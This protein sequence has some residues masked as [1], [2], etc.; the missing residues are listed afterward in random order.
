M[1]KPMLAES[2]SQ[3][4]LTRPL[5][6]VSLEELSKLFLDAAKPN[7]QWYVGTEVELFAFHEDSYKSVEHSELSVVLNEL[8]DELNLEREFESNNALVGLKG[9]GWLFH[10]NPVDNWS[11]QVAHIER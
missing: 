7:T 1:S 2:S 9:H 8:A 10:W 4:F 6:D 11:L 5:K 3:D